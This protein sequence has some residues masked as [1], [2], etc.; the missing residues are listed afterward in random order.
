MA[1]S[2]KTNSNVGAKVKEQ[3]LESRIEAIERARKQEKC[4]HPVLKVDVWDS[5]GIACAECTF[6]HKSFSNCKLDP[7]SVRI[8][9]RRIRKV[10]IKE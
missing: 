6:C 8:A 9:A 4:E 7:L 10:F 2:K 1:E 5:G 3:S